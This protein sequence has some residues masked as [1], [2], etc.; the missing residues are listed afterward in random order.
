LTVRDDHG[1]VIAGLTGDVFWN[2]L[3]VHLLWVDAE[4]RQQGYGSRL[5]VRA[6]AIA[7]EA[8]CEFVYLSTFEFQAPGF[9]S[10]QGY[11]VIGELRG[12]PRGSRRQWFCKRVSTAV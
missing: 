8:S 12:V 3:Y 7:I 9:Y 10:K 2:A 5:L 6:E 1:V 11:S 4:Y